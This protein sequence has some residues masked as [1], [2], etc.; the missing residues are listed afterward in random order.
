MK[1]VASINVDNLVLLA[2]DMSI[3]TLSELHIA[4]TNMTCTEIIIRKDFSDKFFTKEG[5]QEFVEVAASLS[6]WITITVENVYYDNVQAVAEQYVKFNSIEECITELQFNPEKF[7]E[8]IKNLSKEYLDVH[9][10]HLALN[11]KLADLYIQTDNLTRELEEARK[12]NSTLL[13]E[14]R[15][16]EDKSSILV[17]RLNTRYGKNVDLSKLNRQDENSYKRVLYLKEYSRV[18]YTD[19]MLYYLGEIIKTLYNEPVRFLVVGPYYAN[20]LHVQYQ[21]F[22]PHWE[23]TYRDVM[24]ENIYMAGMQQDLFKDI[25]KDGNHSS[26]LIILDRSCCDDYFLEGRNVSYAAIASDIFDAPKNLESKSIISYE[27]G[28]LN[29]PHIADFASLSPEL[30]IQAYSSMEII[31]KLIEMLEKR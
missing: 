28:T 4:L 26:Y 18:K 5:I 20:N 12:I 17:N 11:G 22:I 24:C 3:T 31:L 8:T 7:L 15:E 6:P 25:L 21:N 29:I 27:Q 1:Y 14:Y 2:G 16:L 9:D 23:L 13:S 10:D 19:S 30:K